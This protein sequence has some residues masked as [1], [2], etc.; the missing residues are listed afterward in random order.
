MASVRN[1]GPRQQDKAIFV[2][3]VV[4]AKK[5]PILFNISSARQAMYASTGPYLDLKQ[6]RTSTSVES[7]RDVIAADVLQKMNVAI[8]DIEKDFSLLEVQ[9]DDDAL[10]NPAIM[11]MAEYR[12]TVNSM[13]SGVDKFSSPKDPFWQLDDAVNSGPMYRAP[14]STIDKKERTPTDLSLIAA[15]M[16][17]I[18][19]SPTY[20]G[21]NKY[22]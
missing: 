9:S 7:R 16:N 2:D 17:V 22:F 20:F 13:V 1:L 18:N 5:E 14:K 19:Q 4:S 21:K 3:K 15:T 10:K 6:M 12:N 8:V 11:D